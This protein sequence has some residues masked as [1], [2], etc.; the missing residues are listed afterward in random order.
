MHVFVFA[1]SIRHVCADF[2]S[3][4]ELC[5]LAYVQPCGLMVSK[6]ARLVTERS[7]VRV[8]SGPL[9]LGAVSVSKSL[10]QQ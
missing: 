1:I 7:H 8:P 6:C 4:F 9:G 10:D 5:Y 2:A 3:N